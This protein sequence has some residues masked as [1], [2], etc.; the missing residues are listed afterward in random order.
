MRRSEMTKAE[1]ESRS[2]LKPY[3]SWGEFVR[4]TIT[5]REQTC[6]KGNC[7]CQRGQKHGCLVL[8]RSYKGEVEQLYIPRPKEALARQWVK[9]YQQVQNLIEKISDS[10]WAR[11]KERS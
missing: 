8:S 5:L 4:G 3:I 11:L 2:R 6:G 10:Y 7:K 1:R 9:Q